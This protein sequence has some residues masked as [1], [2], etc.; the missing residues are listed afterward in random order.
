MSSKCIL[1]GEY[2]DV[3][4]RKL[5]KN[6]E[7]GIIFCSFICLTVSQVEQVIQKN[8][9]LEPETHERHDTDQEKTQMKLSVRGT[10]TQ[11]NTFD[12]CTEEPAGDVMIERRLINGLQS[13]TPLD[14]SPSFKLNKGAEQTHESP[15]A[16]PDVCGLVPGD[17]NQLIR[18]TVAE[19]CP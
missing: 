16:D 12:Q 3:Y 15:S 2:F 5:E 13:Q 7:H 6:T 17:Q 18:I 9:G 4:T 14:N 10:Q 1:I 11:I 19:F 8:G